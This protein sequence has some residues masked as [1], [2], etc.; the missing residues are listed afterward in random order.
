MLVPAWKKAHDYIRRHNWYSDVL[1]L[2]LTNADLG[3]VTRRIAE[4]LQS[5][6]PLRSN[7]LRLVLAPKSQVWEIKKEQWRPAKGPSAVEKK[8]RPLAHLS[9]RDQI[10]G[11]AFMI[12]LADTAE[13]R[14]GDPRM[15]AAKAREAGMVSYGHRLFCDR[16]E[17]G[18]RFRWG[19][20]G[21]YRQYF[22]DYQN[23]I[24][25]PDQAVRN[26]FSGQ[27]QDWAI[28]SA[29]LSQFY[30]RVRPEVLHASVRRLLR[31]NADKRLLRSF[32]S[33]FD[34]TWHGSEAKE[35]LKYASQANPNSIPDFDRIALP[36]GLV[37]SGFFANVVLIDF[38]ESIVSMFDKWNDQGEW[39]LLDYC[40][41]VDD[42]RFVVRLESSFGKLK[43]ADLEARLVKAF[44]ELLTAAL[45]QHAPGLV[46][47][48][49]KCG[50]VMGRNAAAGS[51]RV[52]SS[53]RRVNHNASGVMDL[54]V[55]EETLELIE[56][57]LY[58]TEANSLGLGERF[59]DTVL[60]AKPDVGENTVARF[61]ANRFRSAF[62]TLRPMS[63]TFAEQEAGNEPSKES[64]SEEWNSGRFRL[65]STLT[66]EI[67]D[68]KASHFGSRL[69]E[70]WIRDPSNMRLLRVALDLRPDVRTLD[71]VLALLS[72]YLGVRTKRKAP[73]R[74]AWYCAAELLKAGAT[75]TGLVD[76]NDK[77]PDGVDLQAYQTKLADL[78][79]EILSRKQAFPWYLVQQA[80]L[81]LACFGEYVDHRA[82]RRSNPALRH[83]VLLH[84]T[85]KGAYRDL[86]PSEVPRFTL[87]HAGLQTPEK[88]ATAFL[89]QWSKE[90]IRRQQRWLVRILSEHRQL[91]LAV[92]QK[93]KTNTKAAW[94]H[95]FQGYGILDIQ[96]FPATL[97]N[98]DPGVSYS[99]LDVSRSPGNPFRQ[100]Y[101]AIR[102]AQRLI[103]LLTGE[104]VV[105]TPD[106]VLV[107]APDWSRL[108]PES[109]PVADDAFE[110]TLAP[111]SSKDS[112]FRLPEWVPA[113]ERWKYQLGM[114]LRVLL[115]G[116]PD[117]T[118]DGRA[119][120]SRSQILYVPYRSSWLRR[121]YG[122]FN[123]RN[124]FGPPCI[125]ISSWFGSLL[126]RL[127]EWP[128]FPEF[129]FEIRLP[130]GFSEAHLEELLQSRVE[131]MERLYGRS[132]RIPI[133]PV[134]VPKLL[135]FARSANGNESDEGMR[136]MRVGL[137]QTVLPRFADLLNDPQLLADPY[138]RRHR[139]HT[140][141]VLAGIQRMLEVRTTHQDLAVGIELL[142]LP[143]LSI[144]P[145]DVRPLLVPFVMQNRCI[146]CAG[147]VFR[148]ADDGDG[149]LVNGAAWIIPV[150][151]PTGGLDVQIVYQGKQHMTGH[152]RTLGI[153]PYRPAQWI[154]NLVSP[155]NL[156]DILW[157][158]TSAV[159]YDA[160]DLSLA[161]DLRNITDLFIVPALNID[162]GTFDNMAAA[163]HYHM[164]QHVVVA[165]SGEYGGSSAHAPFADKNKRTI[166]H[167][168][169]NEQVAVSFFE[170]D[171]DLYRNGGDTLKTPP[172]NHRR[173]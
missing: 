168:H 69:V 13:T 1:E 12:L 19:N 91:S 161:A 30:D 24:A 5:G 73:R 88:A 165:N 94:R 116:I 60:A 87:L 8:L 79:R 93:M 166:F 85:L 65:S 80:Y 115:T 42:M 48:P 3:A 120:T 137:A 63:E 149:T 150:R 117:Y 31:R 99:L 109:Y 172:A 16:V 44:S 134:T 35:A 23:F 152:E 98:A 89:K 61:A 28:I 119:K 59:Q 155:R 45:T 139:R 160:T 74:V 33:F 105:V 4:E 57:L 170:L 17:N 96:V 22:Q 154:L 46:V 145:S 82:T 92:W 112:R 43:Q 7:P 103:P 122:M 50:V 132:S 151:R 146:L 171:F 38:D 138:R 25:R 49:E 173:R 104:S 68:E 20:A 11:T 81:Y 143:E 6:E 78:A 2:D 144:H 111:L 52:S 32:E 26:H 147:L 142:L 47:N 159:C 114:L 123:G 41:Y 83:Y 76:D 158:M 130:Q 75:E 135:G 101:L 72:E 67:L 131:E 164:F 108:R 77:L 36:Q 127:L 162:V 95:L 58:S 110:V 21:V 106:R 113:R 18:M 84:K 86:P 54:F 97:E 133:L 90:G 39:Q 140:A 118:L 40:R 71:A 64:E 56:T 125:P 157:S 141:S 121:R 129:E 62:R 148:P 70:R 37:S 167:T 124:A 128:G 34:W 10:L 126:N 15:S 29:D 153:M 163:L 136:R 156:S 55:G 102:F 53:M 51:V 14:Q 169:G 27:D 9:V 100:E 107:S 66:R